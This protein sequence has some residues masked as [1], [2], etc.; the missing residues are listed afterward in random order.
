MN[1]CF[2]GDLEIS[3]KSSNK[4]LELFYCIIVFSPKSSGVW[5]GGCVDIT[6][7]HVQQGPISATPQLLCSDRGC[8]QWGEE[9]KENWYQRRVRK[10]GGQKRGEW[11][12]AVIENERG[13][14]ERR[15][16]ARREAEISFWKDDCR[17]ND[18]TQD[19]GKEGKRKTP[20][21]G[22]SSKRGEKWRRKKTNEKWTDRE[23]RRKKKMT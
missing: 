16:A 23:N 14:G 8:K 13:K 10:G 15:L 17:K 20:G 7:F 22:G 18:W 21:R 1:H 12:F 19:E 6:S 5:I 4:P 3:L 11:C 2:I 9:K